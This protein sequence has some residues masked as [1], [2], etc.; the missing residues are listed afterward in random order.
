MSDDDRCRYCRSPHAPSY[1][2]EYLGFTYICSPCL[3][4]F[5]SYFVK[6]IRAAAASPR[7]MDRGVLLDDIVVYIKREWDKVITPIQPT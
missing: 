4:I 5:E 3:D 2:H 1:T 7:D 6:G